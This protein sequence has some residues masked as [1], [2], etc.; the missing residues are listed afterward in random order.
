VTL[1]K[2]GK[3]L[4]K[5]PASKVENIFG[6]A[7]TVS[8]SSEFHG[9]ALEADIGRRWQ[10]TKTE[11]CI[12]LTFTET[13]KFVRQMKSDGTPVLVLSLLVYVLEET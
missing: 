4:V 12:I 7:K 5:A 10:I 2:R 1:A 8:D 11:I 9:A 3:Q 6:W 13:S